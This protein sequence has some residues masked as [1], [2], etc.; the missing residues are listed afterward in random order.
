MGQSSSKATER[1]S[2]E[3]QKCFRRCYKNA[4]EEYRHTLR[5]LQGMKEE[6]VRH[7]TSNYIPRLLCPAALQFQECL[8]DVSGCRRLLLQNPDSRVD[9]AFVQVY[10]ICRKKAAQGVVKWSRQGGEEGRWERGGG[11]MEGWEGG[12]GKEEEGDFG[13]PDFVEEKE[14]DV[15]G[16][17]QGRSK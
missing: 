2:V 5:E 11:E 15:W 10:E 8:D 6:Y 4:M 9:S 12:G 14:G 1:V 3:D 16:E 17:G 13:G 7:R